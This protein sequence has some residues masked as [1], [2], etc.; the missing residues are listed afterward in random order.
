M[1][2]ATFLFVG[3]RPSR[4][5]LELGVSWES[6]A[7]AAAQLFDALE[8]SGWNPHEQRYMNLYRSPCRGDRGDMTDERR[9]LARIRRARRAGLIVVGMGR[10]VQ[11]ALSEAGIEHLRLHH[12]AARGRIRLRS[13]YRRHLR[14]VLSSHAPVN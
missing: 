10:I 7:L 12:P 14:E 9:A 3:E 6:G 2:P 11:R 13:R 8:H 5:S 1:L 4:R